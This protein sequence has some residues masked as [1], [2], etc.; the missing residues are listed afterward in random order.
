MI[1]RSSD[2][3]RDVAGIGQDE[4]FDFEGDGFD[5]VILEE[6]MGE[7]FREGL[8]QFARMFVDEVFDVLRDVEVI[9]STREAIGCGGMGERIDADLE[10]DEQ[11]LA[12]GAFL[13]R[14]ADVR[15]DFEIND[16]DEIGHGRGG[17]G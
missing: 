4:F 14:H 1:F 3:D 16:A 7:F 6:I 9:D 11:F 10:R 17:C 12:L 2:L 13:V 15:V 5:R 8:E